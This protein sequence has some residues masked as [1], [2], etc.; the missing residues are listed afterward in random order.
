MTDDEDKCDERAVVSGT[1][2][3]VEAAKAACERAAR[4]VADEIIAALSEA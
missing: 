2:S 1:E 3:S 4:S